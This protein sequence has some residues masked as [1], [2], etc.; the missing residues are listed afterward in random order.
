MIVADTSVWIEFLR[1]REPV[2]ARLKA[3]LERGIVL[4]AEC[5]F[6]E[7]QS[8]AK[9]RQESDL[10]ESYW[11]SVP[12]IDEAR[13]WIEAGRLSASRG[14]H[15][16]GVGLVD[17]AILALAARTGADIWTLDRKLREAAGRSTSG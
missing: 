6:G 14:L 9:G 10:L 17:A 2:H 7:L 1:N 5:V 8:G 4:A 3:L 16:R 15:A 13:I 11:K 12:K